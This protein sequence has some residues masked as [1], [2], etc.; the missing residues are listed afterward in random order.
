[1]F[2]T[3]H[4]II[5]PNLYVRKTSHSCRTCRS[6]TAITN[7]RAF[8]TG[9]ISGVKAVATPIAYHPG[10]MPYVLSDNTEIKRKITWNMAGQPKQPLSAFAVAVG[11]VQVAQLESSVF[12]AL[13]FHVVVYGLTPKLQGRVVE[14]RRRSCEREHRAHLFGGPY[15]GASVEHFLPA[16]LPRKNTPVR[17]S[18]SS[19]KYS[20]CKSCNIWLR[21]LLVNKSEWWSVLGHKSR[22]I[23]FPFMKTFSVWSICTTSDVTCN[24]LQRSS[25][26]EWRSVYSTYIRRR[27]ECPRIEMPR[28]CTRRSIHT[29]TQ[30]GGISVKSTTAGSGRSVRQQKM[31]VHV[32][33]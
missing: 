18:L 15:R 30:T 1:M 20:T 23:T 16:Y 13:L 25:N 11:V 26:G 19:W 5:N 22:I 12:A 2:C 17:I 9:P 27:T 8:C 32:R 24:S 10:G 33:Q 4:I 21:S 28:A 31:H 14:T 7:S 3:S 29:G 6:Q